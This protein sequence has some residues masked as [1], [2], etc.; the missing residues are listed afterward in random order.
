M[1]ATPSNGRITLIEEG[2]ERTN[3]HYDLE[4][5]CVSPE[6]DRGVFT[7]KGRPFRSQGTSVA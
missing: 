4:P 5:A 6:I 3:G 1:T 7:F 2:Q